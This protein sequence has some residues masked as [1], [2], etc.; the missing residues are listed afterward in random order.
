MAPRGTSSSPQGSSALCLGVQPFWSCS[1]ARLLSSTSQQPLTMQQLHQLGD[2]LAP[3]L[4]HARV[5][6]G[7]QGGD[8]VQSVEKPQGAD[9][10]CLFSVGLQGTQLRGE[11]STYE[12]ERRI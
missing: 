12:A 2:L 10:K 7:V 9:S 6:D 1:S 3:Q 4:A 5:D 11:R 8:G